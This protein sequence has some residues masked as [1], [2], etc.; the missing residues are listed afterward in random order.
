MNGS[1][2]WDV[3]VIGGGPAGSTAATMLARAGKRV[4]V[5]E[6]EKFPRFHIGESLLPYNT[7]IL[8]EIGVAEKIAAAGFQ[9]KRG[10]QFIM[11]DGSRRNRLDFSRGSFTECPE[12]WQVERSVF[13]QLLLDHSRSCGAEAREETLVIKQETKP[14]HVEVTCRSKDGAETVETAAFL[15]D[16][17]G[18]GNFTANRDGLRDYYEG[19]RKLA[20]FAHYTGVDMP[21]GNEE[22]DVL[23]IRRKNSWYWMIPLSGGK[24][25]VGLVMDRDEMKA[26]GRKPEEIFA[27][28]NRMTP[29]VA[30]RMKQAEQDGPVRVATDFSYK[31]R[32]LVAPRIV[33]AGDAAG[34]I[35]PVF[36]SGVLL[37]MTS[38]RDA[39][40]AV[41]EA[42]RAGTAEHHALRRYEREMWRKVGIYW[43]FIENF[44]RYDFAQ[45]FFQP[46]QKYKLMCAIN[47]VLAGRTA[48][49]FAVRWRLRFFFFLAWL[50]RHVPVA[51]RIDV[52]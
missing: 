29:A 16:A 13:D 6:K 17:S 24:T 51:E 9:R 12:A 50:N 19:H 15:I 41:I 27:E 49:P 2:T 36:S 26:D 3:I 7:R 5:L 39:A 10:A 35:D 34:F 14:S 11:G 22:G 52:K 38:A 20:V 43:E 46:T 48:L 1:P 30:M 18:L 21:S 25:S 40:L 31:N 28:A 42:L 44:Y 4:L 23:V 37:A 47:C 32:S 8:E 45:L 33:R